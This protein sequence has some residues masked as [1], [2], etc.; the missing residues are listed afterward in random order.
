[1][2]TFVELFLMSSQ[3][4]RITFNPIKLNKKK[5]RKFKNGLGNK[6]LHSD[7]LLVNQ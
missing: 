1:M 2:K 3:F 7:W 4:A 6:M 5:L